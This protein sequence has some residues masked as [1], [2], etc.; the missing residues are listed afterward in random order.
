[1]MTL[2]THKQ[3]NT[4][5][6]GLNHWYRGILNERKVILM[7]TNEMNSLNVKNLDLTNHFNTK[8]IAKEFLVISYDTPKQCTATYFPKKNVLAPLV[9]QLLVI[10]LLQ[11]L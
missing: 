4:T 3:Y 11:K 7:N 2:K 1:M 9:K 8:K 5:I 10:L 6:Y